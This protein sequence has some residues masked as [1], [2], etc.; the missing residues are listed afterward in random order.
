MALVACA[1]IGGARREGAVELS[2][3]E[4][5]AAHEGDD[6][7]PAPLL[8]RPLRLGWA[9][10]RGVP[11]VAPFGGR[12]QAAVRE[13]TVRDPRVSRLWER[14]CI[15]V[16]VSV[17]RDASFVAERIF[18]RL[19]EGYRV[20][21]L[22]DGDRYAIRA[23]C[24]FIVKPEPDGPVGYVMELLHDRSVA[25]MRAASHLLGLAVRDMSSAGAMAVRAWSL[26]HSGSFPIFMR[27]AFLP[28]PARQKAREPRVVVRAVDSELADFVA[29]RARWYL[30]YLD[31]DA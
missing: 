26:P 15:D 23:M 21:I 20:L 7:G 9:P 25:G 1:R 13:I 31:T 28:A 14:F 2:F 10:L 6:L 11:L 18:A 5:G 19:D 27:H 29:Q 22:E 24:I 30:S 12:R 17:E 4:A 8:V 3:P 16:G